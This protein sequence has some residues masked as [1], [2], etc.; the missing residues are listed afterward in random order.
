MDKRHTFFFQSL[1][2]ARFLIRELSE[3][4]QRYGG[5]LSFRRLANTVSLENLHNMKRIPEVELRSVTLLVRKS[6]GVTLTRPG[7][8]FSAI[9]VHDQC[10]AGSK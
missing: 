9:G 4:T 2:S 1:R 5:S 7:N 8:T 10:R 3:E 6:E